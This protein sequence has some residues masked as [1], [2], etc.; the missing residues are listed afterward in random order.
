VNP[1]LGS[2]TLPPRLIMRALDDLH[3]LATSSEKLADAVSE[4]P[5]IEGRIRE[6]LDTLEKS[7]G[8]MTELGLDMRRTVDGMRAL[9]EAVLVL[10]TST[11][12]LAIAIQPLEAFGRRV[13]RFA[14][15]FPRRGESSG[16]PGSADA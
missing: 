11:D 1:L 9:Q 10:I 2:L 16:P 5:K 4:L 6:R 14:D 12:T 3:T 13:G 15:R 8:A 7:L